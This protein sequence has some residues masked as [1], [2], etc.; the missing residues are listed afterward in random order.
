MSIRG[1]AHIAGAY[2]HPRRRIADRTVPE[3]I[4]EV[5]FGALRDAGLDLDDVDGYFCSA[6][7]PG[8]GSLSMAEYLGLRRLSYID[9]TEGGGA[10]Y[11]MHVGHAAAAIAANKCS[12][13]LVTMAGLP[14]SAPKPPGTAGPDAPFEAALGPN[15]VA[16]Y[17]LSAQRHMYQFGTS[18][19]QLAEIKVAAAHHAQYNPQALLRKPVT[20]EDV[21]SSPLI[22]DPLHR[23]DCCITTDGGGALVI[24][25]SA[26]ARTL[27]RRTVKILGHAETI[28]HSANGEVDLTYT[29]AA[30]TGPKAFA[31]ARVTPADV[32]YASIYDSFTITVLLSLEDLGFCQKGEGGRF[33]VDG[34]LQ[35]PHGALPFNTDGGGLCNNHPD[36]R[37]G[38]IRT[39]E[40][41]RQLRDEA[42][43]E[44]QV[45]N[46]E[47]AVVQG[48]GGDIST[49]A[50]GATLLLGRE[51]T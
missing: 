13:A 40:A 35:A 25:S 14:L 23:L 31:E 1:N 28:K 36:F 11:P 48:H 47:I 12:V 34:A 51:D 15:T 8:L 10:S 49:R 5:A 2:E 46:C 18:S 26:V 30:I 7:A 37:G 22:A 39:I 45:P 4:G 21:V 19:E 20:V 6:D 38:M 50:A 27:D 44:V 16:N 17:A 33:V 43:R 32:D 41:V 29:S 24:V 42:T 9:T 3:V